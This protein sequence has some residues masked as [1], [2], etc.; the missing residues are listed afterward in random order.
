MLCC[1]HTMMSRW[2]FQSAPPSQASFVFESASKRL[3]ARSI[4]IR[5]H[6]Y[7]Q[8]IHALGAHRPSILS[9]PPICPL[10]FRWTH[11]AV[12]R[13]HVCLAITSS[14]NLSSSMSGQP[15]SGKPSST[16]VPEERWLH[17]VEGA[18]GTMARASGK[19]GRDPCL[20]RNLTSSGSAFAALQPS[21]ACG[22]SPG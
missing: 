3:D 6:R 11:S 9:F 16:R 10:L 4:N 22:T 18:R 15:L 7:P 21:C 13:L 17:E 8:G 20:T 5:P 14:S 1:H 2:A 19:S 12:Q